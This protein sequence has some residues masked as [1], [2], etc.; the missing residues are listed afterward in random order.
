MSSKGTVGELVI[1]TSR[2]VDLMGREADLLKQG[3]ILGVAALQT[4][5]SQLVDAYA[6][7]MADLRRQPALYASVAP[8]LRDELVEATRKLHKAAGQ[9][10]IAIAAARDVNNRLMETVVKAATTEKARSRGYADTLRPAA[11]AR[12][13]AVS[14]AVDQRL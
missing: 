4:E 13:E 9:N 10:A 6:A 11:L 14:V 5:K 3:R 12:R 1:L 7:A 8:A 2:L